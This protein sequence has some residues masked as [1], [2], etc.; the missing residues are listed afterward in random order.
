MA[1]T[2]SSHYLWG[3]DRIKFGSRCPSFIPGAES[4]IPLE[5]AWLCDP[6]CQSSGVGYCDPRGWWNLLGSPYQHPQELPGAYRSSLSNT[7]RLA[8][9][10]P[11]WVSARLAREHLQGISYP[12]GRTTRSRCVLL[13]C[14]QSG[15]SW[16]EH[17]Q[18]E[19]PSLCPTSPA[20][21][22]ARPDG[23]WQRDVSHIQVQDQ[24]G[25]N[26]GRIERWEAG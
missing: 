1:D 14:E 11:L 15:V 25:R 4:R 3:W 5:R 7:Q 18:L 6:L 24:E 22:K 26:G 16:Q 20:P 9:A 2:G 19:S 8:A 17:I 10:A 12:L 13:A 23:S 21:N